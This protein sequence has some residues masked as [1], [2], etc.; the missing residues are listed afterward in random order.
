MMIT[1]II[2]HILYFE[3]DIAWEEHARWFS[4]CEYVLLSKGSHFVRRVL[5]QAPEDVTTASGANVNRLNK[6]I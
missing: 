5:G 2:E 4:T 1:V 6:D 3:G